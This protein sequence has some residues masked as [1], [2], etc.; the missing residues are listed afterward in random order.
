MKGTQSAVRDFRN[1]TMYV[2]M[3]HRYPSWKPLRGN[4]A[5]RLIRLTR[6]RRPL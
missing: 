5:A 2:P 3:Y 1:Q 6:G 4:S